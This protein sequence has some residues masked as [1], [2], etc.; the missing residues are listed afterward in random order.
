MINLTEHTENCKDSQGGVK[1]VYL[2]THDPTN[3]HLK[4]VVDGVLISH[5]Q[6]VVY[7]FDTLTGVN[8]TEREENG[9]FTQSLNFSFSKLGN[10]NIQNITKGYTLAIIEDNNGL[11]HYLGLYNG[12]TGKI[13]KQT[14]SSKPELNGYQITLDGVEVVSAPINNDI[15]SLFEVYIPLPWIY[16]DETP[17]TTLSGQQLEFIN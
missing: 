7:K 17:F 8:F 9:R 4:M 5:P 2:T 11:F 16:L 13:T 14:G 12:L 1:N 6:Q 10:N 15:N 3:R